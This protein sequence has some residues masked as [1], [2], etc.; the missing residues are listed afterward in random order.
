MKL[1]DYIQGKKQGK[2]ANRLEREALNDPFWQDAIDG[3]DAVDGDHWNA[4]EN[5]E[6]ELNR[7]IKSKENSENRRW[8]IG[9]AASILLV[10][11]FGSLVY[12]NIHNAEKSPIVMLDAVSENEESSRDYPEQE[13]DDAN[14][15]SFSLSDSE[16]MIAEATPPPLPAQTYVVQEEVLN[17]VDN[18][19][20][21]DAYIMADEE[22][23]AVVVTEN[24]FSSKEESQAK[25]KAEDVKTHTDF[26]EKEFKEYMEKKSSENIC[27]GKEAAIQAH[28]Y[29]DEIGTPV[30]IKVEKSSCDELSEELIKLLKN[31]PK[32]SVRS[33]EVKLDIRLK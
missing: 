5:L 20:A 15:L 23:L 31:G 16:R 4:I 3:F 25:M 24:N 18:I 28:F 11:G 9:I 14:S 17:I 8:F 22:A 13:P 27:F 1:K 33:R 2:E 30:N 7:R 26:G 6:E 19:V 32:W 10:I 29:V 12:F 21:A